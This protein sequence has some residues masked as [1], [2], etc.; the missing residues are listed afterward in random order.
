[1]NI[2]TVENLYKSFGG[3]KALDD[4]SFHV[5]E[6]EVLGI[7]GPNGAGKTTLFNVITGLYRPDRGYIKYFGEDITRVKPF[8]LSHIGISRTFQNLR[9]FNNLTVFE[10]ILSAVLIKKDYNLL[11]A[12]FRTDHFFINESKAEA[13]ARELID[14][15]QLT[16]KED[17]PANSLPYGEQ[18]KLELARALSI[19]PKLLLIDEP[20][21]G[22][23]PREIQIFVSTLRELKK[24]F[25]LTTLI[26]EH[27]MSLVMNISDRIMVMDFGK[28]LTE[29]LPDEIKRD[30]RVIE[31]YLGEEMD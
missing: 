29:G 14:F 27:Q 26:I 16:G 9:L 5:S 15:F 25:A 6:F 10:N 19:D 2:L 3:V 4:I 22:M 11:S 20:G 28:K 23:N 21:A 12:I 7:I 31:A 1:M 18:R 13:K 17:Y 30:K 8:M 24:K